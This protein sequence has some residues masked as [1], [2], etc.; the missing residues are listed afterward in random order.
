M[1]KMGA[2]SLAVLVRMANA[3]GIRRAKP[4]LL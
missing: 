4:R 2:R 3:L 1:K